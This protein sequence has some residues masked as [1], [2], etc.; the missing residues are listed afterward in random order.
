M[1][2]TATSG[3]AA[4]GGTDTD[5]QDATSSTYT[6]SDD[7]VGKTI[8][9]RTIFADDQG[10]SETLTS[11][12]TGPV[13]EAPAATADRQRPRGAGFPRRGERLHL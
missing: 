7:D 11:A 10:N 3:F 12:A 8:K 9:V 13:E 2:P 6:V 1:F 5:T 4:D